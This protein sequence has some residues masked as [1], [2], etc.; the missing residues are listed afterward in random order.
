V[1]LNWNVSQCK[2]F[3][4]LMA[5][6]EWP[7]TER[8]IFATMAVGMGKITEDNWAEFYARYAI[9]CTLDHVDMLS[10]FD[11]YRRIGL[12]T[13]VAAETWVH[14]IKRIGGAERDRHV[15]TATTAVKTFGEIEEAAMAR[16]SATVTESVE[17]QA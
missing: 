3:S 12:V 10:P 14:W 1:S 16:A 4:S 6:D 5:A 15:A 13:N 11:I 9:I 8:V 7:T 17:D 2:N